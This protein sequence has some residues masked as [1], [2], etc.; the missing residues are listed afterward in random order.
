MEQFK[1][2][3]SMTCSLNAIGFYFILLYQR[4]PNDFPY[5]QCFRW[6]QCHTLFDQT[7]SD[8]WPTHSDRGALYP[9]RYIQPLLNWMKIMKTQKQNIHYFMYFSNFLNTFLG[10][11]WLPLAPMYTYHCLNVLVLGRVHDAID[12]NKGPRSSGSKTAP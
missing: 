9:V 2:F 3:L 1:W 4:R 6:Q 10:E 12:L 8:R 7:A 5:I 11:A